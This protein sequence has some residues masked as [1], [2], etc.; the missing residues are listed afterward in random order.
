VQRYNKVMHS[1]YPNPHSAA[2]QRAL[3]VARPA[4]PLA[5]EEHGRHLSFVL[6]THRDR[7]SQIIA[8]MRA[9]DSDTS[10]DNKVN[11]TGLD[12]SGRAAGRPFMSAPLLR[13]GN[14]Q[15]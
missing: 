10:K 5:P 6:V 8:S 4:Q 11:D 1:L 9:A 2:D 13:K 14:V 12:Q 3:L 15:G 7:A